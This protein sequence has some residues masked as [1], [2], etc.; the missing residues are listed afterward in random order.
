[1]GAFDGANTWTLAPARK[2]A[3]MVVRCSSTTP[4]LTST[5]IGRAGS[6][7]TVKLVPIARTVVSPAVTMKGDAACSWPHRRGL[8]P[9]TGEFSTR[10]VCKAY[11]RLRTGI[12]RH[13]RTVGQNDFMCSFGLRPSH[14]YSSGMIVARVKAMFPG[15]SSYGDRA[16]AKPATA[17]PARTIRR[18]TVQRGCTGDTGRRLR[19]GGA[20]E[21]L[22][23]RKYGFSSKP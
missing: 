16:L 8:R 17:L 21:A 15:S 3:A 9:A 20:M 10:F 19:S 7:D 2:G 13:D 12:E 4:S 14:T 6:I 5:R 23:A 22:Q 18:L 1:M 11:R